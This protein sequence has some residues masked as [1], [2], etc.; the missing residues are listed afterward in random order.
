MSDWTERVAQGVVADQGDVTTTEAHVAPVRDAIARLA[1]QHEAALATLRAEVERLTAI[2][3]AAEDLRA[4][5]ISYYDNPCVLDAI[6]AFDTAVA[7]RR[8]Q[9]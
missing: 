2:Q 1:A 7:G 6:E 9:R 5:A 3:A 8:Y 4:A